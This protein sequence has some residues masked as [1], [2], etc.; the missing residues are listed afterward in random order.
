MFFKYCESMLYSIKEAGTMTE[1]MLID[2]AMTDD[3]TETNK[4]KFLDC[5]QRRETVAKARLKKD[6][7]SED[8]YYYVVRGAIWDFFKWDAIKAILLVLIADLSAVGFLVLLIKLIEFIYKPDGTI[9]E[10]VILLVIY[11]FLLFLSPFS[12]N[13]YFLLSQKA[14]IGFR[15]TIITTVYDKISRI[16]MQ[17]INKTN[18]GKMVTIISS[19]IQSVERS[20][21]MVAITITTPITNLVVY[22]IIGEISTYEYSAIVFGVWMIM[23]FGQWLS[24][25]KSK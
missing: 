16:S 7:L 17:S 18:S 3:E 14:S 5:L 21:G 11:G 6:S 19:D 9:E 2:M 20:L 13:Q 8:E 22:I 12:R 1:D 10:G 24:S 23:M 25:F 4:L 15:K